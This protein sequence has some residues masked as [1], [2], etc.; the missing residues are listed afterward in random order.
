ML[1]SGS[2]YRARWPRNR[3][4]KGWILA[5]RGLERRTPGGRGNSYAARILQSDVPAVEPDMERHAS[6][7]DELVGVTSQ[8]HSGVRHALISTRSIGNANQQLA[9]CPGAI[10]HL[11]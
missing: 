10:D 1:G 4:G 6:R 2:L 3:E 7:N 8:V 11:G 9:R 5:S